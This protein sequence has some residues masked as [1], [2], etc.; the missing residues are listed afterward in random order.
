MATKRYELV[1]A[2]RDIIEVVR[3]RR[4][5]AAPV[6]RE[7]L[8][9]P[10]Q[11]TCNTRRTRMDRVV[12][13][14]QVTTE[15]IGSLHLI[16][17]IESRSAL[18]GRIRHILQRP[19]VE[20]TRIGFLCFLI[21]L[22]VARVS[23]SM[24]NAKPVGGSTREASALLDG[25]MTTPQELSGRVVDPNGRPVAGAQVALSTPNIAVMVYNGILDKQWADNTEKQP[26]V[27]TDGDGRFLLWRR[28]SAWFDLLVAHPAGFVLVAD[29]EYDEN[30]EIR[31]Q[32]WGRIE[33]QLAKGRGGPDHRVWMVGLPS[34]A[35]LG[36]YRDFRYNTTCGTDGRFVFE[37]VPPGRFEVGYR[38]AI[39]DDYDGFTSRT[40]VAVKAGETATVKVGG[41]G[42]RVIGRFVPPASYAKSVYFGAGYRD[43]QPHWTA[44]GAS[45]ESFSDLKSPVF[46]GSQRAWYRLWCEPERVNA[47]SS[48]DFSRYVNWRG[49]AFRINSDGSFRIEDVI[50]GTYELVVDLEER[51]VSGDPYDQKSFAKYRGT[52]E[53]P[54]MVEGYREQ[55]LDLGALTLDMRGVGEPAPL[56]DARTLD[57]NEIR[58][59]DYRGKFVLV[60]FWSPSGH[61]DLDH[62]KELH[63]TYGGRSDFQIIGLA[64]WDTLEATN[65]YVAEHQI[66]WP[67]IY[68]GD[69]YRDGIA[70]QYNLHS[71]LYVLLVDPQGKII[72][73]WL[74]GRRLTNTVRDAL[75]GVRAPASAPSNA[76]R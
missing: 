63:K 34:P 6:V 45:E 20:T 22:A 41:E 35:W 38:V 3:E 10:K 27:E 69:P 23:P 40:P 68:L 51:H 29:E 56:F 30:H 13:K 58:L 31:L 64:V 46:E 15:H 62:L 75:A 36:R 28:P 76:T 25:Q 70:R 57:N 19:I 26:L 60:I 47:L 32:R 5:C 39:G 11:W 42:R 18:T 50:P 37:K 9:G 53:V 66:E 24:T 55:P 67:E 7:E 61:P 4:R 65:E 8:A 59:I 73:T 44:R 17:V 71:V 12:M 48:E 49:Y 2:R 16:S 14:A 43:L 33:G 74:T 72:A 54:S 21:V 1:E 52:F